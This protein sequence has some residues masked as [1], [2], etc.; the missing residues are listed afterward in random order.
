MDSAVPA[1]KAVRGNALPVFKGVDYTGKTVGDWT[2]LGPMTCERVG[3]T[4]TYKTKWLC[5][6]ACGSP[7]HW[8]IKENLIRGLSTGCYRCYGARNSGKNNPNWKGFGEIPGEAFNRVRSGA[9]TRN[10]PLEITPEELHSLWIKQGRRC[11][12]TGLPLIMG[13]TASLD[14]ID[15]LKSYCVGN[16]QWVHKT[17]NLMKNDFSQEVFVEMCRQVAAH[18]PNT[19][20]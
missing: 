10:I 18:H 12:L 7:P 2:V 15:S 4:S 14:R 3:K 20:Q 16:V 11:A 13:D 5:Q 19:N 6:C 1:L 8:V 17:I 9:N